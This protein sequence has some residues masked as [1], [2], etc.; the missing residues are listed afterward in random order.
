VIA[1]ENVLLEDGA[2]ESSSQAPPSNGESMDSASSPS[3]EKEESNEVVEAPLEP[4][5]E[6]LR[7]RS[8]AVRLSAEASVLFQVSPKAS[9][10]G[11]AEL[12][13]LHGQFSGGVRGFYG[14]PVESELDGGTVRS[15]LL[16]AG[17]RACWEP[18]VAIV[19]PALCVGAWG[20]R[21]RASATG[22]RGAGE[23]ADSWW[24]AGDTGFVLRTPSGSPIGLQIAGSLLVHFLRP[25]VQVA[26]EGGEN[27]QDNAPVVGYLT[28]AG[29]FFA[30]R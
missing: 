7:R 20:G 8:L 24:V 2:S 11:Q 23:A 28:S 1:I 13:I 16:G 6:N 4:T 29:I 27:R 30:F 10:A 12:D 3:P 25:G 5:R 17:L 22:L 14:F 18:H 15:R 19:A 9:V 21:L 26:V